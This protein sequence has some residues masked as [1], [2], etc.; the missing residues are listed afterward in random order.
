MPT[1]AEG[2]RGAHH[3][4]RARVHERRRETLVRDAP[5]VVRVHH[6]KRAEEQ[7]ARE[8]ERAGG[9]EQA[10]A[11]QGEAEPRADRRVNLTRTC[12]DRRA[13]RRGEEREGER[14]RCAHA[15]HARKALPD[16]GG[17][18][19]RARCVVAD[20][21]HAYVA[22]AERAAGAHRRRPA[23]AKSHAS[24]A[25]ARMRRSTAEPRRPVPLATM[26]VGRAPARAHFLL[27]ALTVLSRGGSAGL[28]AARPAEHA[29]APAEPPRLA[30]NASVA[31]ANPVATRLAA[32]EYAAAA[33][34][35]DGARAIDLGSQ[36][37]CGPLLAPE[38]HGR[39]PA[40][41]SEWAVLLLDRNDLSSTLPTELG[42]LTAL[43]VLDVGVN[44][45]L[46]GTLP[47]ELGRLSRLEVLLAGE[48]A[49]HGTLPTE[50][51]QLPLATVDLGSNHF[52]GRLGFLGVG[53]H[54]AALVELD[55]SANAL[56]GTLPASLHA[57]T[58]LA[59]LSVAANARMS[60]PLPDPP[61]TGESGARALGALESVDL[62]A[63][64]ISGT[65]PAWLTPAAQP[66]LRHLFLSGTALSGPLPPF[67]APAPEPALAPVG[68]APLGEG[69]G[70]GGRASGGVL[71]VLDLSDIPTLDGRMPTVRR[72][73]G[74]AAPRVAVPQPLPSP[75][76]LSPPP[77]NP[78][79]SLSF[80]SPCPG[81]A[82]THA[83]ARRHPWTRPPARPPARPYA[84]PPALTP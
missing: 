30:A 45:R 21:E 62:S 10:R 31:C 74:R 8:R 11:V 15:Q 18:V 2:G 57:C 71:S 34:A 13:R 75:P 55:V 44:R 68:G 23:E 70:D 79:R 84:R 4:E 56:S 76:L 77:P 12:A 54:A 25:L 20:V 28:E 80:P 78:F 32:P 59:N 9:R 69:G 83:P 64:A 19:A 61:P 16:N 82:A 48:C 3:E 38:A 43:A 24:R 7:E 22:R 72:C 67:G 29:V 5:P 66:R 58:S 63:T 35:A 51:A 41:A 6:E 65:L 1:A 81:L 49:L 46:T 52:S 42:D 50:L 36:G 26:E 17:F 27:L 40:G 37:L 33:A 14:R 39:W 60:G 53:P 73:L 47:T